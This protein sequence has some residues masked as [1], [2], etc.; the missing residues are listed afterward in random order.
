MAMSI[1][2]KNELVLANLGLIKKITAKY[3]GNKNSNNT[4]DSF[5]NGIVKFLEIIDR[6]D[7]NQAKLSTFIW[8]HI[9]NYIIKQNSN[10]PDS[11]RQKY[12]KIMRTREF[13][14]S[15]SGCSIKDSELATYLGI[16]EKKIHKCISQINEYTT[17]SLYSVSN[18]DDSEFDLLN[19]ELD[20]PVKT[21]EE[22]LMKKE[23]IKILRQTWN[24]LS[25][26]ERTILSYRTTYGTDLE[27]PLSL[28]QVA[29]IM[30]S[31]RTTIGEKEKRAIAHLK[32]ILQNQGL[33]A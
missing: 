8:S 2:E 30:G 33:C 23:E 20:N 3:S 18:S 16:S 10:I 6:Y 24:K 17:I 14:E 4:E 28:R 21:P 29:D 32:R 7:S 5:Q 22:N 11:L 31:N 27:E 19:M 1:K 26:E 9:Q 15:D 12:N 13:L 25:E